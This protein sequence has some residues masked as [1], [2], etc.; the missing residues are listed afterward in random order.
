M[1]HCVEFLTSDLSCETNGSS[2]IKAIK[3]YLNI[4]VFWFL[5]MKF[6]MLHDSS[7]Q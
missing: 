2:N 4:N 6:N 3:D 7:N 5:V 1:S